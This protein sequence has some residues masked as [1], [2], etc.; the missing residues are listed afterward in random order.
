MPSASCP[1]DECPYTKFNS[2][3][4]STFQNPNEKFAIQYGAGSI[5]GD[6]AQDT[7][8]LEN[9]TDLVIK[10]QTFGLARTA[11]DRILSLATQSN[12]ILGLA[13]PA[14][15]SSDKP[16]QPFVSA[17]AEQKLISQS[18]FSVALRQ[19][20]MMIG[21]IDKDLYQG[22]IRYIPVLKNNNSKNQQPDYTFWSVGLQSMTV[23]NTDVI[24]NQDRSVILDTGTTLSYVDQTTA[25]SIV[26]L[27]TQKDHVSYDLESEVYVVDCS[28]KNSNITLDIAFSAQDQPV[29]LMVNVQDLIFPLYEDDSNSECGFGITY[30]FDNENTYVFG[31]T[32]LRSAYFVFDMGQK[33]VGLATAI[34]SQSK[35]E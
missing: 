5:S 27:I 26:K 19:E 28:L 12:G 22:D 14:L 9:N 7:V 3:A 32:I 31:D 4:S 24:V 15:T 20:S 10:K 13:F 17:L 25:N 6:Y 33:R 23:N 16:Y 11:R 30:N 35:V 21:G 29:H 1:D 34:N 2:D 8:Y 18:V